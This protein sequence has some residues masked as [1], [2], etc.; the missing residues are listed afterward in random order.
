MT[1]NMILEIGPTSIY[2]IGLHRMKHASTT[3]CQGKE[4]QMHIKAHV[5]NVFCLTQ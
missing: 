1:D 3:V 2:N 5:D 4:E